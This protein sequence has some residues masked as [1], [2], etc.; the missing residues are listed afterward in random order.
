MTKHTE[1]K[2]EHLYSLKN[3]PDLAD[4]YKAAAAKAHTDGVFAGNEP[5]LVEWIYQNCRFDDDK[6]FFLVLGIG[7][8]LADIEA[9]EH[10]YDNGAHEAFDHAAMRIYGRRTNLPGGNRQ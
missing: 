8:E 4:I 3:K 5:A 6:L 7:C 10:G 1:G 2:Y 9:R